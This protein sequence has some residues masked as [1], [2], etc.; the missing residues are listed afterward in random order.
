VRKK[1]KQKKNRIGI[2]IY[3]NVENKS[4]GEDLF[5]DTKSESDFSSLK[6]KTS[7]TSTK[8]T[9]DKS[10]RK[11]TTKKNRLVGCKQRHK[12]SFL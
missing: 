3:F 11:K 8:P 4:I 2:W 9:Y 1:K 12:H 6:S 5:L 10:V 7:P